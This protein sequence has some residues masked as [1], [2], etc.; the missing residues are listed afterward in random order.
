MASVS[1]FP[2]TQHRMATSSLIDGSFTSAQEFNKFI[3]EIEDQVQL[4]FEQ[5]QA[6]RDI[7]KGHNVQDKFG[8]HLLHRHYE[9]SENAIAMTARIDDDIEITKATSIA[10]IDHTVIRGQFYRLNE[11]GQFQAYEYE[12]CWFQNYWPANSWL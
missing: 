8:L 2:D 4:S 7:L 1:P 10:E 6:L 3:P 12:Y 11:K 9:M 5:L